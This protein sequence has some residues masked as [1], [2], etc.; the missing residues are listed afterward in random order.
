MISG[1]VMSDNRIYHCATAAG[2]HSNIAGHDVAL[3][4][5]RATSPAIHVGFED[6]AEASQVKFG[7]LQ[8]KPKQPQGA[9][10]AVTKRYRYSGDSVHRVVAGLYREMAYGL[11]D[12]FWVEVLGREA[13]A[14]SKINFDVDPE[15]QLAGLI[16]GL[17]FAMT[18]YVV[19]HGRIKSCNARSYCVPGLFWRTFKIIVL[20]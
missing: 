15:T 5:A 11:W 16:P 13:L 3:G 9:S 20:L 19:S 12:A 2:W 18:D 14:I 6:P 1:R 8:K 7:L 10:V 17:Y 4:T